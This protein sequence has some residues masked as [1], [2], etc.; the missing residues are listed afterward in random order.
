MCPLAPS[1]AVEVDEFYPELIWVGVPGA[2]ARVRG[3]AEVVKDVQGLLPGIA[4][5]VGI[6]GG[7]AGVAEVVEGGLLMIAEKVVG[8]ADAVQRAG[9]SPTVAEL[10]PHGERLLTMGERLLGV[11]EQRLTPADV[12][13]RPGLS[14]GVARGTG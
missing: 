7:L 9:L 12:V 4:G 11:S 5:R 13:E 3:K 1:S 6:A 8:V 14:K 10:S 2:P